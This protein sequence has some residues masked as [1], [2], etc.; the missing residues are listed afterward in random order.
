MTDILIRG[1]VASGKEVCQ[2]DVSRGDYRHIEPSLYPGSLNVVVGATHLMAILP[3]RC[4]V[5]DN[6][7]WDHSVMWWRGCTQD[8]YGDRVDLIITYQV[9]SGMVEILAQVHLRTS[10]QLVDGSAAE[11]WLT[12][13]GSTP[14]EAPSPVHGGV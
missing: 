2:G 6:R 9:G 8:I 5:I 7:H 4:Q 1:A 13:W 11:V 3:V 10:L 12:P 14:E